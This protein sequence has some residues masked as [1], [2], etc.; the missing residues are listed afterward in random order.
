MP[1]GFVRWAGERILG[2]GAPLARGDGAA[3]V[4]SAEVVAEVLTENL[5]AIRTS[6]VH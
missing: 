6:D 3:A 2:L 5:E 4:G 1:P